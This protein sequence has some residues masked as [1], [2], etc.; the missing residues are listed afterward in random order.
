MF[1][2]SIVITCSVWVSFAA[3]VYF[4]R[5]REAKHFTKPDPVHVKAKPVPGR[6]KSLGVYKV[7]AYC[8]CAKCC[9]E[10]AD[11]YT[12]NGHKIRPGDKFV[13]ADRSIPFGT[14]LAMPGYGRVPVLDR[15]GAIKGKR[16]DVYFPTHKAALRWGVKHLEIFKGD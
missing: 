7:T 11:G 14:M 10:Y 12:A 3:G 16:L 2:T 1:K 9:G 5:G 6:G 4:E 13:A 15:G 8:P